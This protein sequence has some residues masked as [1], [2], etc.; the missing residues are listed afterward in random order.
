M[1]SFLVQ[2]RKN[3]SRNGQTYWWCPQKAVD[4]LNEDKSLKFEDLPGDTI[5]IEVTFKDGEVQ[6]K[7]VDLSFNANGEVVAKMS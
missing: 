3:H 1:S 5:T 7:K 4:L 2:S 6:T